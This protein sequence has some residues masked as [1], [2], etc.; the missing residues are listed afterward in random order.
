[1][2]FFEGYKFYVIDYMATGEGRQF[3]YATGKVPEVLRKAFGFS[4]TAWDYFGSGIEVYE[5]YAALR[6]AYPFMPDTLMPPA[7]AHI[8]WAG[9]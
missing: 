9:L 7:E 3:W 5:T 4:D 2:N 8:R 1:M 6:E